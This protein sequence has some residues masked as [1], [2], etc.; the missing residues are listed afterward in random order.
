MLSDAEDDTTTQGPWFSNQVIHNACAT[1]G[2]LNVLLN[3]PDV[4]KGPTLDR[5]KEF[6]ESMSPLVRP[7][8]C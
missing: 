2:L 1:Q 8:D 5:F 6:T 3:C 4:I 7:T